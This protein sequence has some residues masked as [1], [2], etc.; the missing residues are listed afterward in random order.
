M[1][2]LV[3][4]DD[5]NKVGWRRVKVMVGVSAVDG[6]GGFCDGHYINNMFL[7]T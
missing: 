5:N 3:V 4:A 6:G 2:T 1:D 7:I